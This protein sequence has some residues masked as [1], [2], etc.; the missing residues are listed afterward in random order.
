MNYLIFPVILLNK[1]AKLQKLSFSAE[2]NDADHFDDDGDDF[3]DGDIVDVDDTCWNMLKHDA[4]ELTFTLNLILSRKL[5]Q[6][7]KSI[8]ESHDS[9]WFRL[10]HKKP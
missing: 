10:Y 5:W 8:Q 2:E 1:R 3:D 9:W 4:S 7:R 6:S